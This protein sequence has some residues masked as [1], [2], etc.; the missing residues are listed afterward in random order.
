MNKNQIIQLIVEG[1]IQQRSD[2]NSELIELNHNEISFLEK[3]TTL[4][5]A[6]MDIDMQISNTLMNCEI[7]QN[8]QFISKY[9]ISLNF[10]KINRKQTSYSKILR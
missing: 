9:F 1:L 2:L 4:D 3:R 6:I 8:N 10:K 5:K 7:N